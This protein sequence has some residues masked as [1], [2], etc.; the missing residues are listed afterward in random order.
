MCPV[1]SPLLT[2]PRLFFAD[3]LFSS[4]SLFFDFL[5]LDVV[6]RGVSFQLTSDSGCLSDDDPA[7]LNDPSIKS[8]SSFFIA[9]FDPTEEE[10]TN[11][12][13]TCWLHY[14]TTVEPILRTPNKGHHI[15]YLPTK[16]TY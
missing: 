16:E 14:Y 6:L 5:E 7:Q 10:Y 9:A 8:S 4:F 3:A 13:M 1:A 2:F 12:G 11:N 15:N